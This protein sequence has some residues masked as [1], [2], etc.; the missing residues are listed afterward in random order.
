MIP[1]CAQIN[2]Q[3]QNKKDVIKYPFPQKPQIMREAENKKNQINNKLILYIFEQL[4][5]AFNA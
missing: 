1:R 4:F 3:T 2:K 5:T